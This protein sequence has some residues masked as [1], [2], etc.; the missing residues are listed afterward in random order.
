M[1]PP[2]GHGQPR[3]KP[4]RKQVRLDLRRSEPRLSPEEE[5]EKRQKS[6]FWKWF[7]LVAL[8]HLFVILAFMFLH[9]PGP[10]PPPPEQIMSLVAPGDVVK[11]TPGAQAAPH[12]GA[13]TPAP[14]VHH[15]AAPQPPAPVAPPPETAVEPPAPT[16]VIHHK[17][18]IREDAPP[19]AEA[20]PKP[21]PTP[22]KPKVKVD[23]TLADGP[24]VPPEKHV[25]KPKPPR[26]PVE[27][28]HEDTPAAETPET[29]GLSKAEIAARLGKKLEAEGVEHAANTGT[30]GSRE[31][32]ANPFADFYASIQEQVMNKWTVPNLDDPQAVAPIVQIHVEKDGRVPPERVTLLTSSGNTAIDDSALATARSLGYLLQPLPDG[33]PP[34]ISITF[35]LT[36]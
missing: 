2:V 15:E 5:I 14:K 22:P 31:G 26:K 18:I 10:T 7:G 24:P 20:K 4:A 12:V 29:M 27:P 17:P 11:G 28:K 36:H 9:R 33:C 6:Q 23:L 35:K 25:A 16:P 34:D 13:S 3:R 30:S 21:K 32:H 19:I 8:F 1:K